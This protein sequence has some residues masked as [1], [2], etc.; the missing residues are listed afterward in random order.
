MMVPSHAVAVHRDEARY[1]ELAGK[2]VLVTGAERSIGF[3]IAKAFARQQSRLVL[4]AARLS[5]AHCIS[6]SALRVFACRPRSADEIE[7]LADAAVTA[8]A[9]LD[10]YIGV[11]ALPASWREI[12]GGDPEDAVADAFR[13]PILAAGRIAER[14]R[15]KNIRGTLITVALLPPS[16]GIGAAGRTLLGSALASVVRRQAEEQAPFGIRS[17][18][19]AAEPLVAPANPW[20]DEITDAPAIARTGRGRAVAEVALSLARPQATFLSGQTLS[21]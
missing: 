16:T 8:H 17:Y 9:G 5:G 20:A 15:F 2:R 11:T 4:Q 7:R 12:A 3:S 10:I 19:I 21:A 1:P 13:L 14:M 18:G 6:G